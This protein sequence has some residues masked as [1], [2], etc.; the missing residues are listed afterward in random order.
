MNAQVAINRIRNNFKDIP[1][2]IGVVLGGPRA[3]GLHRPSLDIDIRIYYD[4]E[5]DFDIQDIN[6]A[7]REMDNEKRENLIA[8]LG[9]WGF[10]ENTGGC[11]ELKDYH[12]NLVF[13]DIEKISQAI[14]D[15]LKGAVIPYYHRGHPHA[16]LNTMYIGEISECRILLDTDNRIAELNS[17]TF[18]YP[19]ILKDNLISYFISEAI[20]SLYLAKENIEKKDL[21]YIAG[22]CFRAI[23]C[24]NQVLFA[25]NEKYCIDEKGATTRIAGFVE[26]PEDYKIRVDKIFELLSTDIYS[27]EK[28]LDILET[29]IKETKLMI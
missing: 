5:L 24:L 13:R 10:W 9:E 7:V 3:V 22:N 17:K 14:D 1:G 11:F 28:G 21:S 25:L 29:L 20:F 15:C 19:Q 27:T 8:P 18:P 6:K 23:S 26:K 4:K 16:F 2:V 12:V